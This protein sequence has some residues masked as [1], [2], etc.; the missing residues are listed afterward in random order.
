M[1]TPEEIGAKTAD[2]QATVIQDA[3]NENC[4][5]EAELKALQDATLRAHLRISALV[6]QVTPTNHLE[7]ATVGAAICEALLILLDETSPHL[8]QEKK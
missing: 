8:P 7:V 6:P 5:L 4:R 2:E 1:M 3:L